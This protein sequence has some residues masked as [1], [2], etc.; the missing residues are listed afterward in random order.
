MSCLQLALELELEMI[1]ILKFSRYAEK[2]ADLKLC[3]ADLPKFLSIVR[4]FDSFSEI[5]YERGRLWLSVLVKQ[6]VPA[7]CVP[8]STVIGDSRCYCRFQ[9]AEIRTCVGAG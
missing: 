5:S 1:K 7:V 6:R 8:S 9:V 2:N 3:T 4:S